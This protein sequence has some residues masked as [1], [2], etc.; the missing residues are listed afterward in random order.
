[1]IALEPTCH[2]REPNMSR[3]SHQKRKAL[4][5]KKRKSQHRAVESPRLN[6]A[7]T[8]PSATTFLRVAM[9]NFHTREALAEVA[10]RQQPTLPPVAGSGATLL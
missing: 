4:Q 7:T 5:K 1:M 6:L 8:V 9:L 3:R 10:A 2:R